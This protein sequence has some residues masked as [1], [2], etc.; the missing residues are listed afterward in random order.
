[1]SAAVYG[2]WSD[3]M[4]GW[5]TG[6]IQFYFSRAE[7]HGATAEVE[8]AVGSGCGGYQFQKGAVWNRFRS[9]SNTTA[10]SC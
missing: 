8:G 6:D 5:E 7:V 1:M 2:A 3:Y 4:N 10:I 9:A